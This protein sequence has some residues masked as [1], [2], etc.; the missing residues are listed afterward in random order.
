MCF[1]IGLAC[2]VWAEMISPNFRTATL[3]WQYIGLY[4][5]QHLIINWTHERA[6]RKSRIIHKDRPSSLKILV[7]VCL[8]MHFTSVVST[9]TLVGV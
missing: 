6:I 3:H 8:S 9:E 2:G 5:A 7:R 4:E 1:P